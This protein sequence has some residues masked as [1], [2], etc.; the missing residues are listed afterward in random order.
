MRS[1]NMKL[2]EWI[3]KYKHSDFLGKVRIRTL[4][5]FVCGLVAVV[6]KFVV[7][8]FTR[9]PVWLYSSLYGLCIVTCK[10]IYLKSKENNKEKAFFDI[11]VILLL[12]AILFL[13]CVFAKSILLERV[14]RYPIRLA[15]IAN[16]TITVM[17]IVS[18]VGVRKAHQR[19]DRSLLALR[20]TNVSSA[21]MHLVLIEEM[22]L[23][24]SDLEDAEIIQI[25]TFFGCSIG[26][27]IL[28]I[29]LAMLVLYWK[30]YR[31]TTESEED[32]K[33]E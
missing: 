33:K 7:G 17:F 8:C 10:D 25:N 28:V 9:S 14:Y 27:I 11:A 13:V 26:I 16:I 19:Q 1:E 6:F 31:N 32:E 22:F 2:K 20:F 24:T 12:A 29:A 18:L 30:K 23:S 21:L 5:L 4:F 15:V 3:G